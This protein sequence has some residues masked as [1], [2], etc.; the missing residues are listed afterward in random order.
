MISERI[1]KACTAH[2]QL[3]SLKLFTLQ[4]VSFSWSE[5]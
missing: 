3:K 5:V 1:S 4:T 2:L